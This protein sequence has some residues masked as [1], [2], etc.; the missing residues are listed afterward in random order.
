MHAKFLVSRRH[1][2]ALVL[3]PLLLLALGMSPARA[4]VTFISLATSIGG[5]STVTVGQGSVG[6]SLSITNQSN[7][8]GPVTLNVI[9]YHPSCAD[10]SVDCASPEAGVFSVAS[11]ATGTSGACSGVSFTVATDSNGRASFTAPSPVVLQVSGAN[12]SCSIGFTFNVLRVPTTDSQ[13][14]S[15]GVQT[16]RHLVVAGSAVPTGG[17]SPATG[18]GRAIAAIT[19]VRATPA[20]SQQVSSPVV[21][22]QTPFTDK[23][24]VGGVPNVAA[25][26]GT[27]TFMLYGPAD[28]TCAN[29]PASSATVALAPNGT[30]TSPPFSSSFAAKYRYKLVYSGD[31]NYLGFSTSCTDNAGAVEVVDA[32]PYNPLVPARI[33]DTRYG[34]GGITGPIGPGSTVNVQVTGVGGVPPTGIGAVAMNVTVT[35]PTASGWLTLFPAGTTQPL[36]ANLNFTP[37]KTV[38]NLVVVKPNSSG[39]VALFNSHGNS[40]VVFDIAGYFASDGTGN[41]GR[42]QPVTPARILDTRDGTGAPVAKIPPGGSIDLQV[43]GAGG[44]PASGAQ[45]VAV[46]IAVTNTTAMSFITA[47]PTGSTRP[48]AA[49]LN[50]VAGNT[51]SNRALLKLGEGG[52]ITLFNNAGVADVIVDVNGFFTDATLAITGGTFAPQSP[53]RILD[54]RDG[55]GGITGPLAAGSTVDVQIAGRGGIPATGVGSVIL[56]AT[57]VSPSGAGWLTLFP[58]GTARPVISDLNYASGEIRPN[59]VVVKLGTGGKVS[60]F[61]QAAGHVVFDVAGWLP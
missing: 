27:V 58:A 29:V 43:T 35:Q 2:W 47:Y 56:N 33:L 52:K 49:N 11:P 9:S 25:P 7:G 28:S 19:V 15:A 30:A 14:G 42:Y 59:L 26:T 24:T 1:F 46:N 21:A 60:L 32:G 8:F 53:V 23:A 3:S 16:T 51:V 34:T 20:L 61:T 6:G 50:W 41:A 5:P 54:T 36:A 37:G 17:G 18:G 4:Q 31:A 57:V 44:V 13:P 39:Q 38:P 45:G 10:F 22:P 12:A 40:H 55:T 48:L